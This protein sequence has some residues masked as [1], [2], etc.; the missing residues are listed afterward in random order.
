MLAKALTGK[1]GV[2]LQIQ[3]TLAFSV[4]RSR[5]SANEGQLKPPLPNLSQ[6]A[7][8]PVPRAPV[9]HGYPGMRGGR[10]AQEHPEPTNPGLRACPGWGGPTLPARVTAPPRL[11]PGT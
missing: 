4:G 9:S 3:P 7:T 1:Q 10:G 2:R 11:P 6:P 5:V 8:R